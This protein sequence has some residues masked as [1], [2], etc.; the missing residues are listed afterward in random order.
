MI[1]T[2]KLGLPRAFVEMA[3][4][5]YEYKPKQ[6]SVTSLLRGIR[7]TILLRRYDKKIKVDVSDMIWLLWG[8][9]TH[10]ILEQQQEEHFELKEGYLRID[11]GNGYKLSGYFDLYNGQTKAITDYKTCSVWKVIFRDYEDWKKQLLMYAWMMKKTGFPVKR[12]EIVAIMKDHSKKKAERE[13]GY[14][15]FPVQR[16]K[17]EFSPEDFEEIEEFI[18]Q[19]FQV[20]AAAEKLPDDKLPVCTPEERYRN[21]DKYAVM[22]KGRKSALRVLDT[23]EEAKKW[24]EENGKGEYI[25][26][27]PGTDDKCI[28]YCYAREFCSYYQEN[29]KEGD[30]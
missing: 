4:R 3:E 22:K 27:R 21:G 12:G 19:R 28:H 5:E 20:I 10:H 30:E 24:M 15:D 25:E 26:Y 1:I 16:I 29:V 17:F 8:Q 2:N 13:S 9:A 14:P 7:E 18:R 11:I 6:Y 23:E